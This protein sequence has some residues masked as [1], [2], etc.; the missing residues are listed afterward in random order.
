MK[1][2]CN[3]CNE[4]KELHNFSIRKDVKDGY[5]SC[6]KQCQ[7]ET[8]K[9]YEQKNKEKISKYRKLYCQTH[10]E[11]IL[12]N[13]KQ[14][15]LEHREEILLKKQQYFLKN[16]EK[17]DRYRKKYLAREGNRLKR[18]IYERKYRKEKAKI[19]VIFRMSR[20]L[21]AR[22]GAAIKGG[23]KTG[24]AIKDLGCSIDE[25]KTY[26]ESKFQ[27]GM[28]WHNWG[29][30]GWHLDHITPLSK[31]DLTNPEQFKKACH[32]TN[33][34]PLWAIDNLKKSNL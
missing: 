4:T 7:L 13:K 10:K 9:I 11:I 5:R 30:K 28:N 20:C 18:A 8:S 23:Q 24:S 12:K 19:D 32:Y 6:C 3:K 31:L 17:I 1:K 22:L 21:R 27:P 15:Y 16:K 2:I 33:L 25:F 26:I 29:I 14:Y 34:Q